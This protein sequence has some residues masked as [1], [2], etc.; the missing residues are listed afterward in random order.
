MDVNAQIARGGHPARDADDLI[1]QANEHLKSAIEARERMDYSL[2][3]YEARWVGRSMR[4][5]KRMHFDKAV[6]ALNKVTKD[7]AKLEEEKINML[8]AIVAHPYESSWYGEALLKYRPIPLLPKEPIFKA[9][10]Y[11]EEYEDDRKLGVDETM[12]AQFYLGVV[13]QSNWYPRRLQLLKRIAYKIK[14]RMQRYR[15]K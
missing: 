3:W 7:L 10:L 6:A 13:Y 1:R 12:L 15:K 14:R 9:Y 8:D 4:Y 2:A 5:L 11:L